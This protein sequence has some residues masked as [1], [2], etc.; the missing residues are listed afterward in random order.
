MRLEH[1]FKHHNF[2][3]N[4][5]G[6][7]AFHVE[8]ELEDDFNV[9]DKMRKFL[10]YMTFRQSL[11]MRRGDKWFLVTQEKIASVLRISVRTVKRYIKKAI[12]LGLIA[13][14]AQLRRAGGRYDTSR[15]HLT[16]TLSNIMRKALSI[17]LK[18]KVDN[19]RGDKSTSFR[20]ETKKNKETGALRASILDE[21]MH[22]VGRL[23]P[24]YS[25]SFDKKEKKSFLSR[26]KSYLSRIN[27]MDYSND[28][29]TLSEACKEFASS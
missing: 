5:I 2:D 6:G 22:E 3:Y 27:P 24:G 10:S 1:L 4:T 21:L 18:L 15:Y 16:D 23:Q 19:Q 13:R 14:G 12:E 20:N 28:E 8:K 7:A 11:S 26:C 17:L 29:Y 25:D 9:S